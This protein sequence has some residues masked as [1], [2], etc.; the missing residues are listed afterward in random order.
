MSSNWDLYDDGIWLIPHRAADYSPISRRNDLY[1][2][3]NKAY[4][5]DSFSHEQSLV[6]DTRAGLAVFSSWSHTGMTN[7][8]EDIRLALGREDFYAFVGGLHLYKLTDPELNDLCD[9]IEQSAVDRIF[10]GHC[11]GDHAFGFL[12][13]RLGDRI[14][15]FYSGFNCDII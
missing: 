1:I 13:N 9:E 14:V 2:K 5:P 8:L 4:Y 6:I 12:R 3:R 10:T 11:T 15:Q 7:I